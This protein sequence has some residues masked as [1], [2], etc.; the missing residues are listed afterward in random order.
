MNLTPWAILASQ[1]NLLSLDHLH[2]QAFIYKLLFSSM[3][4]HIFIS[5]RRKERQGTYALHAYP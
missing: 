4:Y 5:H 2:G 3:K 1:F